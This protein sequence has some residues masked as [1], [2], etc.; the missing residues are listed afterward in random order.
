M[1]VVS[2]GT[3][4]F[5][6]HSMPRI[7]VR[8]CSVP[9]DYRC[10]LNGTKSRDRP[11]SS[12]T[13]TNNSVTVRD[14][15]HAQQHGRRNAKSRGRTQTNAS[16]TRHTHTRQAPDTSAKAT[17]KQATAH[18]FRPPEVFLT[19]VEIYRVRRKK[20]P[21]SRKHNQVQSRTHGTKQGLAMQSKDE[22]RNLNGTQKK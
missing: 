8:Y 1:K 6:V 11:Q 7:C 17:A 4:M 2:V 22:P 5:I 9:L 20:R 18:D 14:E 19:K 10:T 12:R 13:L 21:A 16:H 3:E 15:G